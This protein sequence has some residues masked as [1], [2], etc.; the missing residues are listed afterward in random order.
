[1]A[2]VKGT[3]TA[4][5]KA[6]IT[7]QFGEEALRRFLDA[8]P[9]EIRS[10][11]ES[12][13]VAGWVPASAVRIGYQTINRMFG[14]GS[15]SIYHDIGAW[16]ARNDL[17]RFFKGVLGLASPSLV[18]EFLGSMWRAYYNS[19]RLRVERAER[20][21]LV[22]HLTDFEDACDEICS[23]VAGFSE[24][25]LETLKIRNPRVRHIACRST[26]AP[27]CIFEGTWEDV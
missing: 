5:Q 18:F 7:D 24:A 25:L 12:S 21:R 10:I 27:C 19:G 26:G 16:G 11:Y 4:N 15:S 14:D 22:V 13:V 23:D 3:M 20:N 17:P 2:K 1:M 6:Y 8:L 9:P